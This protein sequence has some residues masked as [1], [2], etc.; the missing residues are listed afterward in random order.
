MA[1]DTLLMDV[2]EELKGI[3]KVLDDINDRDARMEDAMNKQ[4][5]F[6]TTAVMEAMKGIGTMTGDN[7]SA[8]NDM[9]RKMALDKEDEKGV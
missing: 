1:T 3:R 9:F 2:I 7:R 8:L 4:R 6:S 5:Q